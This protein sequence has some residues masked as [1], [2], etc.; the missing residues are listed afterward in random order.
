M[1]VNQLFASAAGPAPV[2]ENALLRQVRRI[3]AWPL[4]G[5]VRKWLVSFAAGLV[6]PYLRTSGIEL[7]SVRPERVEL[8]LRNLRKVQNHMRT[9]HASA[10]FLLAEA[11]TGAVLLANLP[12]GA[13]FSTVSS[14]VEYLARAVGRLEVVASLS[15]EQQRQVREQEK[16]R[17]TIP[18]VLT[19]VEGKQPAVFAI[20][21]SW[22]HRAATKAAG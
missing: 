19:D 3:E 11:A 15:P 21:W 2:P 14:H 4:P 12:D 20:E 17:L 10:M 9:V 22:K 13:R 16:G 18:V 8:S 1:H 5:E 7:E 6:V